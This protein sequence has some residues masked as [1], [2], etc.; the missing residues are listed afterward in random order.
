MQDG[1]RQKGQGVMLATNSFTYDE[2]L[3]LAN[4]L[5]NKLGLTTTVI[6]TGVE[7]QW[8]INIW[9]KSMPLLFELVSPYFITEMLYKIEI[10]KL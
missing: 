5:T 10:N 6:K 4:I 1:S 7:G 9:K 8:R 2:C 3:M